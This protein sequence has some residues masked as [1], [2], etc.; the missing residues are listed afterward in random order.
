M[1]KIQLQS[2]EGELFE[3]DAEI[4]ECSGTLSGTI[5]MAEGTVVPLPSVNSTILRKVLDWAINYQKLPIAGDE[6]HTSTVSQ[7][8]KEF[9]NVG[10][11]TLFEIILA[12]NY[13]DMKCLLDV[14]CMA[15]GKLIKGKTPGEI[16]QLFNITN[17]SARADS[18]DN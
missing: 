7:F 10:Q 5:D 17:G 8:Y 15:V 14:A 4:M 16:R 11:S 6:D 18:A 12:A 1:P 2:S 3:I 13:L 9:F